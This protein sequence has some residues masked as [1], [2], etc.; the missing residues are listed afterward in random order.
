MTI[1]MRP[2]CWHQNFGPNG[3][4][5][6]TLGL[7]LNFFSSVTADFNISS[8]L[9]WAIQD[10]WSSGLLRVSVPFYQ[11]VRICRQTAAKLRMQGYHTCTLFYVS[12]L[13]YIRACKRIYA[14][15]KMW[16]FRHIC[17]PHWKSCIWV[18]SWSVTSLLVSPLCLNNLGKFGLILIGA[19]DEANMSTSSNNVT[20]F[21][22]SVRYDGLFWSLNSWVTHLF[23]T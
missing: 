16:K 1:V 20:I 23:Y 14:A 9:R 19:S 15:T 4:P 2:S 7:C 10:Q 11:V 13:G 18:P 22:K 21:M 17:M 12:K 6:P 5:A 3:L 8:A